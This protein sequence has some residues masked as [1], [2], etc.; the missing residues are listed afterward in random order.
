MVATDPANF[1]S[2][3]FLSQIL[4]NYKINVFSTNDISMYYRA[5]IYPLF[6]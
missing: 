2:K 5:C 6:R 1:T 3:Y 4:V